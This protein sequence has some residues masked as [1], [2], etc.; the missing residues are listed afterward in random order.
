MS[1]TD[2]GAKTDGRITGMM[3]AV[4]EHLDELG[5]RT[6]QSGRATM[7]TKGLPEVQPDLPNT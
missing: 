3:K 2:L 5:L 6:Y 7:Y 4:D 1:I